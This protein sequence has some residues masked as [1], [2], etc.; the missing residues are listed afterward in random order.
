LKT[1]LGLEIFLNLNWSGSSFTG[2]VPSRRDENR[3][4]MK[5]LNAIV[6]GTNVWRKR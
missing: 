3:L 5:A 4:E 6:G 2:L 1:P